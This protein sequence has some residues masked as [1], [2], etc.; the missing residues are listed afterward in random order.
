MP[1]PSGRCTTFVLNNWFVGVGVKRAGG[2]QQRRRTALALLAHPSLRWLLLG[3]CSL[4]RFEHQSFAACYAAFV[5]G[6]WFSCVLFVLDATFQV[7]EDG[8][9]FFAKRQLVTLFSA[10]NYCG[11]FDN[12]GAM[13]SVDETL[14]CSFQVGMRDHRARARKYPQSGSVLGGFTYFGSFAFNRFSNLQTRSSFT[15]VEAAWAPGVPSLP[16]GKPRNDAR[17]LPPTSDLS[18]LPSLPLL[19]FLSPNSQKSN[20]YPGLFFP[21]FYPYF[22]KHLML[23]FF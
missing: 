21:F 12:A 4:N 8:Y 1:G 16:Q 19:F 11:E 23:R 2:R 6:H 10:P 7:V 3:V 14:M 22:L 18:L 15:G 13:M 5:Q 20:L 17:S 9:E